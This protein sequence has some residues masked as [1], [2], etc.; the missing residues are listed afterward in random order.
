MSSACLEFR[1]AWPFEC[2]LS[3]KVWLLPLQQ[4]ELYFSKWFLLTCVYMYCEDQLGPNLS[5]S[6]FDTMKMLL[7]HLISD[8][9]RGMLEQ[10]KFRFL[11]QSKFC[12]TS[13]RSTSDCRSGDTLTTP[14][15]R[16]TVALLL[17]FRTSI[18]DRLFQVT[19]DGNLW[20]EAQLTESQILLFV[21]VAVPVDATYLY[22]RHWLERTIR[23]WKSTV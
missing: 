13:N 11:F 8:L 3:H 4:K 19:S 2:W 9:N 22:S 23:L 6:A 1:N 7:Y 20:K 10:L 5:H 18:V 16:W 12:I 21:V 15:N 17:I 14:S